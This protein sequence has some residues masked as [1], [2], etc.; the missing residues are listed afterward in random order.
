MTVRVWTDEQAARWDALGVQVWRQVKPAETV[1]LYGLL[2]Q[3]QLMHPTPEE[4][5]SIEKHGLA[6]RIGQPLTSDQAEYLA[7]V[8]RRVLDGERD[9]RR[10][11]ELP[12]QSTKPRSVRPE[13][14]AA[15]YLLAVRR[16]PDAKADSLRHD[17]AHSWSVTPA[18]VSQAISDDEHG[19]RLR[20]W[21]DAAVTLG[22]R[23][24]VPEA[25]VL[26]RL[27]QGV[28][29]MRPWFRGHAGQK[30]DGGPPE[31][32]F[33]IEFPCALPLGK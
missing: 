26:D 5:A 8:L 32:M 12:I 23:Y 31:E 4:R 13:C 24:A 19:P 29:S 9:V 33:Y 16:W 30:I 27:L 7:R 18:R 25:L 2:Q 11:F 28:V 17:I 6:D 21:I 20:E 22:A 3:L 1:R 10:A 14:F 15:E